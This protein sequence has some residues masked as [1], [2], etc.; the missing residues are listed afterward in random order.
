M[1]K[2]QMISLGDKVI[3]SKED[4][5]RIED[6]IVEAITVLERVELLCS[7]D[8]EEKIDDM[9]MALNLI[10]HNA[11]ALKQGL[12]EAVLTMKRKR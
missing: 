3:A 4:W 7:G 1:S 11:N 12:S 10:K 8:Y 9:N 5:L 6:Q 2:Y